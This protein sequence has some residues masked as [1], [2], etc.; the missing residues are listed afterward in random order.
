VIDIANVNKIIKYNLED[1][2]VKYT[3]LGLSRKDV[4]RKIK[5]NHPDNQDL[6]KLSAMSIQR[7][8]Q[9]HK[10]DVAIERMD[11]GENLEENIREEFRDKMYDLD[12][13]VHD[14]LREAK[15]LLSKAKESDNINTQLKAISETTKIIEQVRKN[16][17]SLI[18]FG[19]NEFKPVIEAKHANIIQVDKML[20]TMSN[21][22]CP[23]CRSKIVDLVVAK[24]D[25]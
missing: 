22:F 11:K 6:R 10:R 4:A 24:E 18:Q 25:D 19:L 12:D 16:W 20:M 9:N 15:V 8:L 17:T 21:I 7:F 3:D 2:V 23:T 13:E 1:E 14:L 5:E